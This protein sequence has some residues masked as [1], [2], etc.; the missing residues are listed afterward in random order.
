MFDNLT[1]NS[2]LNIT[3]VDSIA[4]EGWIGKDDEKIF[5]S[6]LPVIK[7]V[8]YLIKEFDDSLAITAH[9]SENHYHSY[10]RIPKVSIKSV[11]C[12]WPNLIINNEEK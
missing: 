7:S 8:G 11:E 1:E 9:I 12:L 3:W 5:N 4:L 2:I 10:M 6:E